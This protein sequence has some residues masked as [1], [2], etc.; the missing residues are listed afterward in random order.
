[1]GYRQPILESVVH[2]DAQHRCLTAVGDRECPAVDADSSRC[3]LLIGGMYGAQGLGDEAN[4]SV[5]A[6]NSAAAVLGLQ[7]DAA[8]HATACA[9]LQRCVASNLPSVCTAV[10]LPFD[11]SCT[12]G[13]KGSS[14][15]RPLPSVARALS[16]WANAKGSSCGAPPSA[17]QAPKLSEAG[18]RC[19]PFSDASTWYMKHLSYIHRTDAHRAH[20]YIA[21]MCLSPTYIAPT[22][23]H[24]SHVCAWCLHTWHLHPWPL[25][26]F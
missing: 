10:M 26:R 15:G 25:Y 2:E 5:T 16:C 12:C 20:I 14:C 17:S 4:R 3:R 23:L 1:M 21:P 8:C 9:G 7:R 19:W 11:K 24:T 22:H 18:G 6:C 13:T